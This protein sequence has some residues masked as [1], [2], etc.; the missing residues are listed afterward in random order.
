MKYA[1][2]TCAIK[3]SVMKKKKLKNVIILIV[4]SI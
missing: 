1:V 4:K 2:E 3:T